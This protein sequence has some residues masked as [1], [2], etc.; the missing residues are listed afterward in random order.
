[1]FLLN[2]QKWRDTHCAQCMLIVLFVG[3]THLFMHL[4]LGYYKI[5]DKL[6]VVNYFL[7]MYIFMFH[8]D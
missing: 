5:Y 8:P 7:F 4:L 3:Y 2:P 6:Q 1:M